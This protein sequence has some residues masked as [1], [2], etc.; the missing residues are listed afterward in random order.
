LA[1]VE[2]KKKETARLRAVDLLEEELQEEEELEEEEPPAA[3]L[4]H[5]EAVLRVVEETLQDL[6]ESGTRFLCPIDLETKQAEMMQSQAE[7]NLT[8]DDL[9]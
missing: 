8:K 3:A 9:R 5:L 6:Q 7:E 4:D 1:T 2:E